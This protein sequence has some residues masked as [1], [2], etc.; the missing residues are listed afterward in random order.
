MSRG[1][2]S[3]RIVYTR[4]AQVPL[5]ADDWDF[6]YGWRCIPLP[7][8]LDDDWIIID[9]SPDYRTGGIRAAWI[10]PEGRA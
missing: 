5:V 8:T 9:N 1:R 4:D 7:P 2:R 6:N 3:A 10:G